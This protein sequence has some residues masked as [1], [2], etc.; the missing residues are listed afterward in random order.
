M[1]LFSF[2]KRP[3]HN[4]FNYTPRF[5]DPEKEALDQQ[6]RR[7]AGDNDPEAAKDRIR[8]GLKSRYRG[9]KK[10]RATETRKS[11]VRLLVIIAVLIS[12]SMLMMQSDSFQK[13]IQSFTT[14]G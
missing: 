9:D 11:N 13:I 12:L 1:G 14:D 3:K 8:S 2:N 6:V 4:S 5:Y 10:F 7:H